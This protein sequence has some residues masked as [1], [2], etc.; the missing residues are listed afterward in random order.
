MSREVSR[1]LLNAIEAAIRASSPYNTQ[2]WKFST[3]DR[4]ILIYPDPS[5][6]LHYLDPQGRELQISLG[7]ALENSVF[8]LSD[9]G[10]GNAVSI[11]SHPSAED[12]IRVDFNENLKPL[13]KIPASM[14]FEC[15]SNPSRFAIDTDINPSQLRK[16]YPLLSVRYRSEHRRLMTTYHRMPGEKILMATKGS[17]NEVLARCDF[18]MKN[19]ELFKLAEQDRLR[20]LTENNRLAEQALRIL[21]V[22]FRESEAIH[23][24][25]EH[26]MVWVGLVGLTD[27][28]RPGI[29]RLIEQFHRAGIRTIMITGDQSATALAVGK[30]L[31]IGGDH[32][33]EIIDSTRLETID[34]KTLSE[35]A[36]RAHIFSRVSPSHKLKIVQALQTSGKIV[37]MTGDGINDGPAL[38]IA[39][40]GVAMGGN[41]S[42]TA[43]KVADAIL[44]QDNLTSLIFAVKEGRNV[45][46]DIRKAVAYIVSQ[47]LS[48]MLFTFL[49]ILS[50][51][52][53][54]LTP[55][56]LLWVN[57]VTDIFP[58]LALSQ[59][60]PESDL[61]ARQPFNPEVPL[62]TQTDLRKLMMQSLILT[63]ASLGSYYYGIKKYGIGP[64][65]KTLGFMTLNT[66]SLLH[67]VS[68]RSDKTSIFDRT[69]L[70]ENLFIP[71]SMGTG[72][73]AE[74]AAILVPRLRTFL[75][76]EELSVSDLCVSGIGAIIPFFIIESIKF[77]Q[78]RIHHSS[79]A[80]KSG[81][82]RNGTIQ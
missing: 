78:R 82:K 52:G 81:E 39:D 64:R 16:H 34:L 3:A 47:N 17:P 49:A 33:P 28:I 8:A 1:H 36:S 72:F 76:T 4:G 70:P 79:K 45:H 22:A 56:Q 11:Y 42:D 29:H 58:E 32:E 24:D 74:I 27:P 43:R 21:G 61:M 6:L 60:P 23:K 38:K 9:L 63:S 59:D 54:P 25:G 77:T 10:Y 2:P 41:G 19:G 20:I 14:I 68:S 37:A 55:M 73:I 71:L 12:A 48:E 66:A 26:H 35:L 7:C 31:K 67:T 30:T 75:K 44:T 18:Y 62:V 65:S 5:R 80:Q 51:L 69:R 15:Q 46:E 50:G 13:F 57:L 40:I 53:E